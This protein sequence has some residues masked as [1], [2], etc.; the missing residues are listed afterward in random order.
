M[1][2]NEKSLIS[3]L[4]DNKKGMLAKISKF[5]ADNDMN[6]ESLTLSSADV[7]NKIHRTVAYITGNRTIIHELCKEMEKIEGIRSVKNFMASS[8]LERELG[9]I[10]I[11][12]SDPA[13]SRII[14][15]VNDYE[16]TTIYV[17]S[18]IMICDVDETEENISNFM[19][20][21]KELTQEVEILRTGIVATSLTDEIASN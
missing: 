2:N 1:S 11:K 20:Q 7:E 21:V 3:I 18:K 17:D 14:K 13:L 12:V 9:L 10:K 15:L 4:A 5:F 8:F 19:R 6:I 16:G